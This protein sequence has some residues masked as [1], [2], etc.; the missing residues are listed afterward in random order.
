[1][2]DRDARFVRHLCWAGRHGNFSWF[3]SAGWFFTVIAGLGVAVQLAFLVAH[4]TAPQWRPELSV[5]TILDRTWTGLLF[6]AFGV[7]LLE[8][9]RCYR[10]IRALAEPG[11]P[12]ARS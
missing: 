7:A 3:R 5:D 1:L 9:G 10:I 8:L 11:L 12:T 6:L 4:Y 2:S